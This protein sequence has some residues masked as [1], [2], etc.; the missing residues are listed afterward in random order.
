MSSTSLP[1]EKITLNFAV[2]GGPPGYDYRKNDEI[3][4]DANNTYSTVS[5]QQFIF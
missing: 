1:E 4:L 3:D 5:R 2:G